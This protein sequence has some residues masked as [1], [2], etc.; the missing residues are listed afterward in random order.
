MLAGYALAARAKVQGGF[1]SD[2]S[3]NG[4]FFLG[5]VSPDELRV[6]YQNAEALVYPSL[7]EGFGL[8]PLE[9]MAA[10]IPVIAMP[11]SS[12]PEAAGDAAI[13]SD[14]LAPHDL[15]RVMEQVAESA[16][17]RASL[18][19]RGLR[20]VEQVRWEKTAR[21]TF[22]AYRKAVLNPTERALGK[23][24]M[25]REA[26]LRWSLPAAQAQETAREEPLPV[27]QI[28]G[29]RSAWKAST[30]RSSGES[31]A[32]RAD[33]ISLRLANGPDHD[34]LATPVES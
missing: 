13:F 6:L 29:V 24:R 20:R 14:G 11:F 1:D 7:Y 26:I 5:P 34:R 31:A 2:S 12:V 15:A 3:R 4:V 16:G 17:L 28:L 23:R 18:R 22:E 10:G 27:E 30:R 8:P 33:S 9:A 21:L 19:E 32:R 25:L